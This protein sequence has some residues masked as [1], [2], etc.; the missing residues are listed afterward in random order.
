MFK[1]TTVSFVAQCTATSNRKAAAKAASQDQ[2]LAE[3]GVADFQHNI[4]SSK[5]LHK[6]SRAL[7]SGGSR[8][9]SNRSRTPPPSIGKTVVKTCPD[10]TM[11]IKGFPV[12]LT[13]YVISIQPTSVGTMRNIVATALTL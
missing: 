8:R 12:L 3:A 13:I 4:A 5:T 11:V 7:K 1:T 2:F 9:Y 10:I 6:N